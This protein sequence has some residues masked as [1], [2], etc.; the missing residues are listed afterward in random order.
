MLR[1]GLQ[2]QI[3]GDKAVS[4]SHTADWQV[5]RQYSSFAPDDTAGLA[6]TRIAVVERIADLASQETVDA[7]L[8][9]DG[10]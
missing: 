10:E 7:V 6:E 1:R 9:A 2:E 3:A 4:I 8:V 5:G